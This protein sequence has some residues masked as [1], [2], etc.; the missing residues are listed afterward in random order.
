MPWLSHLGP[1]WVLFRLLSKFS[2]F[3]IINASPPFLGL[4]HLLGP[5]CDDVVGGEPDEGEFGGQEERADDEHGAEEVQ[6]RDVVHNLQWEVIV[7]TD[8]GEEM[9]ELEHPH[10]VHKKDFL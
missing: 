9:K 8:D 10:L 1:F 5:H 3:L 4:F 2:I 6:E 7:V